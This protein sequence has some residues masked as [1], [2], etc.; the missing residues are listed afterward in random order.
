M[1]STTALAGAA[2]ER[3]GPVLN[4][5]PAACPKPTWP[6]AA[7]R[8]GDHG[9]V[10]LRMLIGED[11]KVA[12][13]LVAKS[14]GSALLDDAARAGLARCTFKPATLN[15]MPTAQWTPLQ[16]VW[17]LNEKPTREGLAKAEALR[18]RGLNGDLDAV[19]ALAKMLAAGDGVTV[20]DAAAERL[21]R[22]AA[23]RG[24]AAAAYDL[25]HRLA[26]GRAEVRKP[27]E[28][29]QW[30]DKAAELGN[31]NAQNHL[32]VQ[33]QSGAGGRKADP[34]KAAA[35]LRLAAEQDHRVAQLSL[36]R[37]YATGKGVVQDE[38]QAAAWY[39]RAAQGDSPDAW[40][41][42]GSILAQGSGTG[43]DAA[44]AVSW[45]ARAAQMRHPGA[46]MML[47]SMYL[48]GEGAARNPAEGVN[49]MRRSAQGGHLPAMAALGELLVQGSETGADPAAGW[50]WLRKA[51]ERGFAPAQQRLEA[52]PAE[53]A[54]MAQ[55]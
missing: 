23:E 12:D 16:Y 47:A 40:F 54:G 24:H 42:L 8:R 9:T 52:M 35:L 31:A 27:E 17:T 51:A 18:T 20:N 4:L 30:Y 14:S 1:M 6:A 28:A 22:L 48:R 46:E 21:L 37:L 44:E 32:A 26:T 15:G 34:V 13:S 7:L 25:A 43:K 53:Y 49:L 55:R 29:Q 45:L 10:T 5:A 41:A 3:T 36:A 19:H 11:G 2:A 39:R 33:Y 50:A 38:A